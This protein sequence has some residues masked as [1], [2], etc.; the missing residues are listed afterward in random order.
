M[1]AYPVLK[2]EEVE[3][4]LLANGFVFIRQKGSHKRY[5]H[6]DGRSTTLP[7]HKGR[8]ISP[9]LLRVICKEINMTIEA[10]L[11]G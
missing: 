1:P 10:F 6:E 3:K 2:P 5:K 4:K 8:D 9:I 11:K 7:F